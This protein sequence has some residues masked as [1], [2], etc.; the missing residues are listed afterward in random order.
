[1]I[2]LYLFSLPRS[3]S[4][5]IQR[6]LGAHYQIATTS[7]PWILLPYL[8]T[9]RDKGIYAEYAHNRAVVAIEDFCREFP[10][11]KDDYLDEMRDFIL[12]LYSKAAHNNAKYFLDKTPRYHLVVEDV[13]HLFPQGKFIFLWRNPLA[14]VASIMETWANGKW[15]TYM[16]N[17]DLFDGLS[18][19]VA[20]YEKHASQALALRYEDW[21]ANPEHE[22]QRVF[23]YLD[24]SFDPEQLSILNNVQLRGRMGDPLGT[25]GFQTISKEPLEKWKHTLANPFRKAW[26]RRYLQWIGE[27]RLS[28]MG[29][30]LDKLLTEL[31]SI[32][33]G[34]RFVG[35]D[36]LRA[37]YGIAYCVVEPRILKH[38]LQ[39]LPDWHR[40][41][42]H[43]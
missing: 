21:I 30:K 19:L 33:S 13:I 34:L 26:C 5:L 16:F 43:D 29:Y 38:K 20:A 6:T 40:A 37:L 23:A 14:I 3:G 2:P 24:L 28:V 15:I 10:K 17:V 1:M 39:L 12:R 4:T 36:V 25:K 8:Y 7:E 32:P 41:H 22:I 18:N 9:M 11:G 27:K 31:D 42:G 35:S